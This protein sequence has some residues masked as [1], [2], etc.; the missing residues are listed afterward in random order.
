[1]LP[2]EPVE[3]EEAAVLTRESDECVVK[4]PVE[5]VSETVL[6]P[7]KAVPE[8]CKLLLDWETDV[9]PNELDVIVLDDS[10]KDFEPEE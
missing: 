2:D 3:S 4:V 6:E 1:M 7:N 8:D 10:L 9:E 5:T